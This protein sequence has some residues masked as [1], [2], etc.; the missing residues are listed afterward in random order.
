[1]HN[2]KPR[3][4]EFLLTLPSMGWLMIFFVIPTLL[5]I[6]MAFR[7]SDPYGGIGDQWTFNTIRDL[8][9]P[10]YPSI[11][12]RT[13]WLSVVSTIICIVTAI[14]ASYFISRISKKFQD[15]ILLL[16]IV[17]FWINFLIRIFA[18]KVFLHPEGLF[19]Q[20]LVT[21]HIAG[22]DTLL[23]YRPEAVLVVIVYSYLP[24]AL[25]PI[26]AAAEKFDFHLMEAA[27]DLGANRFQ[28]FLRVYIPGIKMGLLTAIIVVFI[29]ALGSYVIPDI[30]G[31]PSSEMIGNKIAQRTFIDR[32]LP[33]ASALSALLT[34]AVILPAAI[35]LTRKFFKEKNSRSIGI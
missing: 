23:L 34:F 26:Y 9:N 12:W 25:L 6:A 17:P 35:A 21:L 1:M 22:P 18:W 10:N 24:F 19:K 13:L 14:P 5:V 15:I 32:N 2:S 33:H 27:Y 16:I 7:N 20:I 31:G 11:I 4:N 8:R 30:V 3:K 29:P 28:A